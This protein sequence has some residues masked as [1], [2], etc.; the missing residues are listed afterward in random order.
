MK[1]LYLLFFP[2]WLM[3]ATVQLLAQNTAAD[4]LQQAAGKLE[5]TDTLKVQTLIA[6][7]SNQMDKGNYKDAIANC[8]TAY[9]LAKTQEWQRGVA[10]AALRL[11]SLLGDQ[12]QHSES[13]GYLQESARTYEKLNDRKGTARA[14]NNIAAVYQDAKDYKQAINYMFK[15]LKIMERLQEPFPIAIISGNIG[16]LYNILEQPDKALTYVERSLALHRKLGNK[17]GEAYALNFLGGIYEKQGKIK[18]ALK[19]YLE[20]LEIEK[21][22][23]N[24]YLMVFSYNNIGEKYMESGNYKL[25]EQYIEEGIRE[26]QQIGAVRELARL[27][28]TYA[29]LDSVRG[30]FR[31]AYSRHRLHKQ[32]A[33]SVFNTERSKQ[34][35]EMQAAFDLETKENEI[36]TLEQESLIQQLAL[37]RR[38]ALL[39]GSIISAVLLIAFVYIFLNNKQLRTKF[40]LLT[41]QQRWRRAQMNPHF[42]FN[43]L[44]AVQD[45]LVKD[46]SKKAGNYI[47]KFSRLMR[48]TLEQSEKEFTTLD[49]EIAMLGYYLDLQKLRFDN[50]FSYEITVDDSLETEEVLIPVMLLQPV[51]ENAVEH[52]LKN[53]TGEGK[54]Q[55]NFEKKEDKSL[56]IS[57]EDNGIGREAATLHKAE[58]AH[59]SMASQILESRLELLEKQLNYRVDFAIEDKAAPES[60][61]KVIFTIPLKYR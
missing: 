53:T 43:A 31:A 12:S 21:L 15:A 39:I 44:A 8:K 2:M 32:Y 46:E 47:A 48:Q 34:V 3:A 26:A 11:G 9:T 37:E 10:D 20:A 7:A 17:S 50:K 14:L 56:I 28:G 35:T 51:V 16:N 61:T 19:C 55:I 38:S 24:R 5:D 27:Y 49:D 40:D 18:D 57:I 6:L 42:F 59:V 23:G 52:G 54:I 45:V 30:D 13:L 58:R 60:G 25:A 41:T 29:A 4:S 1:Q 36:K 33:D 22:I